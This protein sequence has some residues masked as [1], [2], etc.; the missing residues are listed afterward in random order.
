MISSSVFNSL[1]EEDKYFVR[2]VQ[3][4]KNKN[5]NENLLYEVYASDDEHLRNLKHST[6]QHL[7]KA[8]N[9]II[10]KD[11]QSSY[12]YFSMALSIFPNDPVA[13]YYTKLFSKISI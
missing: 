8:F 10:A 2:P 12:K 6:Q 3:L 4:L 1:E 11:P 9:A 7:I 13:S 5:E